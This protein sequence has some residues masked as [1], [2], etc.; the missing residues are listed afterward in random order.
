MAIVLRLESERYLLRTEFVVS[1]DIYNEDMNPLKAARTIPRLHPVERMLLTNTEIP[2]SIQPS[3][4][5][6]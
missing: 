3:L 1:A 5:K 6:G 2:C 4:P